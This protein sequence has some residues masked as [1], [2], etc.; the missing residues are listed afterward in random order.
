MN[1]KEWTEWE[2][3]YL[4]NNYQL[5]YK[6]LISVL[7]RTRGA[8]QIKL[9]RLGL[10]KNKYEL[11]KREFN[12]SFF[13]C[14]DTEEKAYWLGFI[15]ADG[16]IYIKD[17]NSKV[18][19]INLQ[20]SDSDFLR[21]F[22]KSINGNFDIRQYEKKSFGKIFGVCEVCFKCKEMVSDLQQYITP[23]K[24]NIIRM[25][26]I[27]KDLQRHFLRGFSDGDG[28]FYCGNKKNRK[29]FE[30]VSNS[31]KMLEDIKDIFKENNINSNIYRKQNGNYKIGIYNFEDLIRLHNYF[32][33]DCNIYMERKYVKSQKILNLAS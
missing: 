28:C 17:E 1:R 32:Y 15:C 14:I 23:N 18:L 26:K 4:K 6:E 16:C 9:K 8:I 5:P 24:T 30:I 29:S 19:K 20:I 33:N 13:H 25:P 3:E 10:T 11:T 12:K 7:N 31:P 27:Q 21:K 2:I 22:I